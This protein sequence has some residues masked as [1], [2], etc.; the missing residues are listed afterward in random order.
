[1]SAFECHYM[2]VLDPILSQYTGS[3]HQETAD[4]QDP[5]SSVGDK[6]KEG[7]VLLCMK[8]CPFNSFTSRVRGEWWGQDV[9][10]LLLE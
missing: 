6:V 1:M 9:A 2:S 3:P 10:Q 7:I 4:G 5:L 8:L